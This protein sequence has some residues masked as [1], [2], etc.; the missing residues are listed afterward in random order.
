MLRV[1]KGLALIVLI[2]INYFC[3]CFAQDLK[4]RI[5]I[6]VNG[7]KVEFF[8]E[9]EKIVAEGN[10]VI[11]Y[12]TVTLTCDRITV[13]TKTKD[14]FAE[15]N[16]QLEDE[17]G[18][19]KGRNIFYNFDTQ[20]GK[21][22]EANIKTAPYYGVAPEVEKF[23]TK[24][25]LHN[26]DITTCNLDE[27][28]YHF[29]AREIEIF[30]D[31]KIIAMG[32]TFIVGDVPIMYLPIFVQYLKDRKHGLSFTPGQ[33]REWGTYLLSAYRFYL[34][35]A[36]RGILHF[37][38]RE[39]KGFGGGIDLELLSEDFGNGL[40][41][42]YRIHEHLRGRGEVQPFYKYPER[43]KME[44]RHKWDISDI[45]QL[46]LEINDYSDTNFLTN[47]YYKQYE[48]ESQ[49]R[50]YLLYSH[51]YPSAT[52]SL[53]LQKRFNH[54]YSET[55]KIPEIKLETFKQKIMDTP[56]YYQHESSI[57]GLTSRTAL[58]DQDEDTVRFDTYNQISYPFKL[59]LF[60]L[61]P[62]VGTRYTYYS[63]DKNGKEDLF[64]Y[65][66]YS[67]CSLL[68]KFYRTFND[69]KVNSFGLEID[70]L[71]H[72]I[73]PSLE[74]SYI[75]EPTL[76]SER[77]T[78]F[79]S[80]DSISKQNTVTLSLQN[81]LQTKRG[82]Q[83]IDFLTFIVSSPY[84]FKLEGYGG[85]FGDLN[86]DL[87]ILPNS[88]LK[89]WSDAAFDYRRRSFRTAD[90]D[91]EFPLGDKGKI[92]SGYRYYSDG[93][94]VSRLF[95]FT[96][97]RQLNAKWKLRTYHRLEFTASKMIEEQEYTLSRDLHCWEVEFTVNAKKKKGV[98]FWLGF[99]CKAFPD[100]GFDVTKS[101]QQ[102]KTR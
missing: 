12:G 88:W 67:G 44:Y 39:S 7:D 15:G 1:T 36:L 58:T 41:R 74:Y 10:V 61:E 90:F 98:T 49:P 26:G 79:E 14:A 56:F 4:E 54:F 31:E 95:N 11:E 78:A 43:Y 101:H 47:Y 51:T 102:P 30:P 24:F 3:I 72:I 38:W 17:K 8:T 99:R 84:N 42:Y 68:T 65:V 93:T 2:F 64:R 82:G 53:L 48:I 52:L 18:I 83:S 33:S 37:D 34:N 96:F 69:I 13:F 21:I 80:I 89:F 59:A 87:E 9:L 16:V 32:V 27:P 50:S 25:I 70:K 76:P 6:V 73:T 85:R 63:K 75:N 22:V 40:F 20:L 45:D 57:T 62:S 91:I 86:F 97:E 100:M 55:E 5:P 71:R 92:G 66:F 28:H 94:N 46:T 29:H 77:L 35:D 23:P 60:N 19:I 81:K